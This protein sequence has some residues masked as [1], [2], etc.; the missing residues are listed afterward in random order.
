VLLNE[1]LKEHRK[2][3]EQEATIA[4]LKSGIEALAATVK[5][6]ASQIQNVSAQLEA[7]KPAPL[8]NNR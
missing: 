1:F 5:E 3:E 8:V 6:Q 4:Q 2:N 7:N